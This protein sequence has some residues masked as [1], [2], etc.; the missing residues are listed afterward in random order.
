MAAARV[1]EQ[2]GRRRLARERDLAPEA[3]AEQLGAALG[4]EVSFTG[5]ES[6]TALLNDASRC[7]ELFG[8]P[9]VPLRT[10]V[11]WQAA[12]LAA[13]LPTSGKPTKFAVRDGKF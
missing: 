12:W 8:Y 9:Q 4:R 13:G 11:E 6:P 7:H 2:R 5:T 1:V 10:L 3:A